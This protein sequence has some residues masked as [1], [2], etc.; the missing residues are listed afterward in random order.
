MYSFKAGV[1]MK[2]VIVG[3]GKIGS[4]IV[5]H[6]SEEN[7]E[8]IVIDDDSKVIEEIVNQYDVLGIS[9]NGVSYEMQKEAGVANAD[10]FIAVTTSDE[11]NML[12]CLI[13]KSLV[14][15]IL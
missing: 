14:L 13:A 10:I 9:G 5:K 4:A 3:A 6:V 11:A 2:I 12:A 8:V 7:H 1:F 15:S